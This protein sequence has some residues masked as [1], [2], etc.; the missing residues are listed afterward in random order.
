MLKLTVHIMDATNDPIQTRMQ[1]GINI[2]Y[3]M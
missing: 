1:P 2:Q 3:E